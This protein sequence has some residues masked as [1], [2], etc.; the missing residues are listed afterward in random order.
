MK[1]KDY[2]EDYKKNIVLEYEVNKKGVSDISR[3]YGIGRSLIYKWLKLYGTVKL[4][5]ES[6]KVVKTNNKELSILKK[7]L[8]K[9]REENE[10]LKKAI[11]IFTHH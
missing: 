10:I 9:A 4:A 7:D 2:N 8:A 1:H 6:G 5:D 11:A 3:E